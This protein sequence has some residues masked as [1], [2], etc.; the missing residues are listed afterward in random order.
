MAS[1]TVR[2]PRHSAI[3]V[4]QGTDLSLSEII[5]RLNCAESSRFIFHF[6]GVAHADIS[7]T[8]ISQ[9]GSSSP[10]KKSV[11]R[12]LGAGGGSLAQV[13]HPN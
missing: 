2:R 9:F 11:S 1:G 6:H 10:K 4:E 7:I 8:Q 5:S 3:A 13:C 12:S